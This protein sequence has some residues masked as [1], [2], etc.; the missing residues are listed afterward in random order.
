MLSHQG[1]VPPA[2]PQPSSLDREAF[3][4]PIRDEFS[5]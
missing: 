1:H 3:F 5:P 4:S 2:A